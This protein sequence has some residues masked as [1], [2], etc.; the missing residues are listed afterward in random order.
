MYPIIVNTVIA[1]TV[2]GGDLQLLTLYISGMAD[3]GNVPEMMIMNTLH[4]IHVLS[5]VSGMLIMKTVH[6]RYRVWTGC[7]L[8][9]NYGQYRV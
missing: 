7:T 6:C 9:D 4:C 5:S 2:G 8:Y 3:R 1:G